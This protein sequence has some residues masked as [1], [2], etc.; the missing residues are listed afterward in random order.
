MIATHAATGADASLIV[1][2]IYASNSVRLNKNNK[3]K[4]QNF[5][6]VLLRRFLAVGD[7]IYRSGDGGEEL[8]RYEQ[9]HSVTTILYK[10]SHDSPECAGAI[11]GRRL[12]V[13]QK[14]LTKR[15]RDS[16][17]IGM[18][19]EEDFTAWPSMGTIL[20]LR[21]C[22]HIFPVTDLRHAVVTPCLLLL[23]QTIAQAPVRSVQDV[24]MGLLCSGLMIEYTK[25]S[26]RVAPEAI[27][28]IA[29]VIRLFSNDAHNAS[30]GIPIPTLTLAV[31]YNKVDTLREQ[32]SQLDKDLYKDVDALPQLSLQEMEA[33]NPSTAASI[34]TAALRLANVLGENYKGNL[35]N[36]EAETLTEITR[37]LLLLNPKCKRCPLPPALASLVAITAGVVAKCCSLGQPRI[38]LRRRAGAKTRE[39]AVASLAPRMEDP[40]R[41]YLS[42]D[43]NKNQLQAQHDKYRREY[44]REHK[45]AARELRLD[46]AFI[47]NERRKEKGKKD[48]SA[49]EKRNKNFA[50]MEQ[51]QATIN[52][53]V[54]QGGALL[55]GGGIGVAR[56]KANTAKIG[57]KKGGKLR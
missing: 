12:G 14:A 9:L 21:A 24:I 31:K 40:T 32:V 46:A 30:E 37:A 26:K 27:T 41:Y 2:R 1:R 57:I 15:L 49:R 34:L 47:E 39:V 50:W 52:Q 25:E 28:F 23:G 45:A 17:L 10:M 19:D 29:G 48:S 22:G 36:A 42:K 44:K 33:T 16:E 35:N 51:E 18:E 6:D 4:M 20:L 3:E 13:L 11:W 7:A 43:K 8:A 5:Y 56:Q 55:R 53:Q 54:A 38:P